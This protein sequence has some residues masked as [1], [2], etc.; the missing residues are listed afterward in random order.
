MSTEN[1]VVKKCSLIEEMIPCFTPPLTSVY[2][3]TVQKY[4]IIC[5]HICCI[6]IYIYVT[7]ITKFYEL[8]STKFGSLVLLVYLLDSYVAP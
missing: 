4:K 5:I 3:A 6:C 1:S 7:R 2:S 8:D